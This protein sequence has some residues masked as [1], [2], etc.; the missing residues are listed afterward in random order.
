MGIF[1]I[2]RKGT[3]QSKFLLNKGV[4][5]TADSFAYDGHRKVKWNNG[6]EEYGE[7]WKTGDIIGCYIDLSKREIS[8]SRN[9]KSFGVAFTN[10]PI[11][12]VNSL[13]IYR[14]LPT[15]L[16]SQWRMHRE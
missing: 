12:E 7:Y 8:F 13:I 11:G 3:L 1:S 15:S 16:P 6:R 10:I 2:K 4:G 14:T 9:G 5:D